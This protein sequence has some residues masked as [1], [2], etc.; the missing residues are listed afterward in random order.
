MK[1]MIIDKIEEL[2]GNVSFVDLRE[3]PGFS[4]E[5]DYWDPTKNWV[6]WQR[7]SLGF[8]LAIHELVRDG[9]IDVQVTSPTV[10]LIDD[11]V[12]DLPLVKR[13]VKY[14]TPS[15]VPLAFN[16]GPNFSKALAA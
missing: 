7:V 1:Q 13:D 16:K 10:Y 4:G 14:K 3:L 5:Q 8:I 2:G 9:I 11:C 6:F 15:W 12:L